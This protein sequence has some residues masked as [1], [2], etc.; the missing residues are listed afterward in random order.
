MTWPNVSRRAA[1]AVL[2][3]TIAI[4]ALAFA[5]AG[6]QAAD[7]KRPVKVMTRNVYF[8]TSLT[9]AIEAGSLPE[10]LDAVATIYT[11]S[12]RSDFRARAR[13]LAREIDDA[14][15]VL[16]GLQ[17]VAIWRV[18][19][20]GVLDGPAT[21]AQE[22]VID[23]LDV[24]RD[25]LAARGV[26]YDVAR[27]QSELDVEAPAWAPYFRDV[28]LTSRDVILVKRGQAA[29]HGTSSAYFSAA[30]TVPTALGPFPIRASWVAADV[31]VNER[32]FRFVSTHLE[33]FDASVR[34]AQ[35][36]ELVATGGPVGGSGLPV[37]LVGDMNSD[38]AAPAPDGS[39][40]DALVDAGLADTWTQANGSAPGA[41]HGFGEL[42][43]DPDTSGFTTRIDH[44]LTR[45][46]KRP[47]TSALVTGL[48][49]DNRT[50]TGLWPSDHAGVVTTV[51]P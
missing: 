15:P 7:P 8:G 11:N 43:D 19:P 2:C 33:P 20:V 31:T 50:P 18:G 40:F 14:D 29:V 38:P 39:A 41:T 4:T 45:G 9:R 30:V 3:L 24:L 27:E 6:A 46:A 48:D 37:V 51:F 34:A 21:P 17:E 10:F 47:A 25:E 35:A 36:N 23:Y 28:R 5:A 16:I 22:V 32:T 42:L 26:H 44:V 49:G 13:S 1:G 12:Q